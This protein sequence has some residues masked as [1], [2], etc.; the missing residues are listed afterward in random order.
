MEWESKRLVKTC[1]SNATEI[2]TLN[3]NKTCS[4][5]LNLQSVMPYILISY[6]LRLLLQLFQNV[7][8]CMPLCNVPLISMVEVYF[9][10]E[11]SV[12]E[13]TFFYKIY[14]FI[15]NTPKHQTLPRDHWDSVWWDC[16]S[17]KSL[18]STYLTSDS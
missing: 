17:Y 18:K 2:L 7:L 4:E 9:S 16:V 6:Q 11:N 3:T 8:V 13:N 1:R 5:L 14:V 10:E 12:I 15:L